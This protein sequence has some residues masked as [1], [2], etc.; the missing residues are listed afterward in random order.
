MKICF[1][2]GLKWTVGEAKTAKIGRPGL[3]GVVFSLFCDS[4]GADEH[5]GDVLAG[6]LEAQGNKVPVEAVEEGHRDS[7]KSYFPVFLT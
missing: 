6:F 2:M 7:E 5:D 1:E 3:V 4:L